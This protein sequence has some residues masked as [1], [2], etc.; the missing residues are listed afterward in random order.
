MSSYVKMTCIFFYLFF[1]CLK[2]HLIFYVFLRSKELLFLH[3]LHLLP[4]LF[5]LTFLRFSFTFFPTLI[6]HFSSTEI[7]RNQ[8]RNFTC[9]FVL[10]WMQISWK[11]FLKQ[12]PISKIWQE[13]SSPSFKSPLRT[14]HYPSLFLF[15]T[16]RTILIQHSHLFNIQKLL[17]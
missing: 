1:V 16:Y 11:I 6:L 4:F 14:T 7:S 5:Y 13:Y 17:T 12:G 3:F 10:I 9:R 15:P 2:K 8:P